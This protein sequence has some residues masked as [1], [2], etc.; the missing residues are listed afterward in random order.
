MGKLSAQHTFSEISW[1]KP[2]QSYLKLINNK[3]DDNMMEAI[4]NE[5]KEFVKASC[6]KEVRD[7]CAHPEC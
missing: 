1:E 4:M 5:A 2:T 7:D 3:V 6:E